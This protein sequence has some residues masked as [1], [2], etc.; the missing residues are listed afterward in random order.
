MLCT[1]EMQV[2]PS[3]ELFSS[4]MPAENKALSGKMP[5]NLSI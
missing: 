3:K 5:D 4:V 2:S 1:K